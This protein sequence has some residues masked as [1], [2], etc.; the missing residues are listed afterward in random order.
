MNLVSCIGCGAAFPPSDGP[1]HRY[2][3]S[4]P[5]CWA[6]FG[7]VL[8]RE[9]SDRAYARVHRLTVDT[10]AVQHPGRP[11]PQS[12]QSVALHL[13]SLCLTLERH[14]GPDR[15]TDAI[16]AA[17]DTKERFFWLPPPALRGEVTIA[18]VQV[19]LDAKDHENRV[20]AWAES[21]WAAWSSHHTVVRGWLAV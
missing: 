12:V 3:E 21:V 13:I 5:G 15:A 2:M 18:D 19:A 14:F 4:S 20:R 17:A 1:T 11:S 8:A 10:Y 7:E 16:R 6:A 9:Y